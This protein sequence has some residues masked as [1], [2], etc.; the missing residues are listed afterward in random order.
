MSMYSKIE[1][2]AV[3]EIH[4]QELDGADFLSSCST[5]FISYFYT[6]FNG[7]KNNK[8]FIVRDN[9]Q[10]AG[11]V[12]LT[13]SKKG[14]FKGFVKRNLCRI[15]FTPSALLSLIRT[16]SMKTKSTIK[17]DYDVDIVY[18]AVSSKYQ[19]KGNARKLLGMVEEYLKDNSINSYYLQVFKD[20]ERAVGF[21]KKYGF[22]IIEEYS[23]RERVKL[24]MRMNI[25]DE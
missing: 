14:L 9:E 23:A 13:L 6:Y 21:Y 18:I 8:L 16:M 10:P 5:G 25:Q 2:D 3:A 11:F 15:V 24:L 1:N 4:K 17:H 7:D 22:E 19:S 20:N 12:F